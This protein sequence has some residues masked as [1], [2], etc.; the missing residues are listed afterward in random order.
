MNLLLPIALLIAVLIFWPFMPA[1]LGAAAMGFVLFFA[2][3]LLGVILYKLWRLI[4]SPFR[5]A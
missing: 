5:A 4:T 3:A 1:V 2:G